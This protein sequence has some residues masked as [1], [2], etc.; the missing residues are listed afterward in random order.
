M[1][2]FHYSCSISDQILYFRLLIGARNQNRRHQGD[3]SSL[4]VSLSSLVV[5]LQRHVS[6]I[7]WWGQAWVEGRVVVSASRPGNAKYGAESLGNH[8]RPGPARLQGYSS[9]S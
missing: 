7:H 2:V 8:I 5:S 6:K 9:Q 1:I 4:V 3:L